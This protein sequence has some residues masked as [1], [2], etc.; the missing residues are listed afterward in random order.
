MPKEIRVYGILLENT[1]DLIKI[2]QLAD[3]AF[4]DRAETDGLVYSLKGFE[5]A[6]NSQRLNPFATVI[7]FI[8]TNTAL[9]R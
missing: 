7:R 5:H 3:E 6:F 2:D 1:D 4:M 8:E 9:K